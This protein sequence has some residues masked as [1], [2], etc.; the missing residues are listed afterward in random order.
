M[1]GRKKTVGPDDIPGDILKIGGEAM[2]PYLA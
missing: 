2:I 1:V